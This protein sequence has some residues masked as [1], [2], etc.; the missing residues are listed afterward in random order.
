MNRRTLLIAAATLGTCLGHPAAALAQPFPDKPITIVV[1]FAPGASDTAARIVA[2]K[3]TT[4]L[5]QRVLVDNRPGA[6]GAIGTEL[7]K[8]AA[9]DGYTLLFGASSQMTINPLVKKLNYDPRTDFTNVGLLGVAPYVL[10]INSSIPAKSLSELVTWAKAQP[11]PLKMGNAGV[12]SLS[13]IAAL[14]FAHRTGI[15]VLS[16]PY[17]G[18]HPAAIALE[19]GEAP[20][21]VA[22]YVSFPG[23]IQSGKVRV[24]AVANDKRLPNVPDIPTFAEAE[25]QNFEI[26]QWWGL[27]GPAGIPAPI[28]KKL[29]DAVN[30]ALNDRDVRKRFEDIGAIPMTGTPEDHKAFLLKE[31]KRWEEIIR[32]TGVVKSA[33]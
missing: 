22:T 18:T 3:L 26:S 2:E 32:T 20:A 7:V 29:N 1:P 17:K 27:Y 31:Y 15:K 14:L 25:L 24:L 19:A 4:L 23:G 30:A 28:L 10:A 33:S 12:G 9:P 8:R 11:T 13:D 21:M 5:G 6:S 16:V